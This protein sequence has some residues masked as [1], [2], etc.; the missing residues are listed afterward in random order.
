M[1][2]L[3]HYVLRWLGL[4]PEIIGIGMSEMHTDAGSIGHIDWGSL[5][6]FNHIEAESGCH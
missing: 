3:N 6:F 2:V 1:I 5:T 4:Q